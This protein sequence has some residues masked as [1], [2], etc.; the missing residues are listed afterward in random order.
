MER[1]AEIV[2]P[3]HR[4]RSTPGDLPATSRAGSGVTANLAQAGRSG[5][6]LH[7]RLHSR[8]RIPTLASIRA[9]CANPS[10]GCSSPG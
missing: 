2:G 8:S 6:F 1:D 4:K 5:R 10:L 3:P 9:G 7:Q